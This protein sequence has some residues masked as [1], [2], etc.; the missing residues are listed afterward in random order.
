MTVLAL[1][2]T[3]A[4]RLKFD[5]LP[6]VV[7]VIGPEAELTVPVVASDVPSVNKTPVDPAPV[8]VKAPSLATAFVPVSVAP[9]TEVPVNVFV[10]MTLPVFWVM[11]VVAVRPTDPPALP[12]APSSVIPPVLLLSVTVGPVTLPLLPTVIA[13]SRSRTVLCAEI[14]PVTFTAGAF[15]ISAFSPLLTVPDTVNVP[16]KP[17]S[18][19]TKSLVEDV[20]EKLPSA[21]TLLLSPSKVANV[22]LPVSVPAVIPIAVTG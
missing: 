22:P 2:V 21:E 10:V 3:L 14:P 17:A 7:R 20:V 8:S 12:T 15:S 11:V 6:V 4:P 16:D 18:V 13:P 5:P 1:A 19:S 9:P